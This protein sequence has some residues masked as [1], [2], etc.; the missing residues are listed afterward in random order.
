MDLY[1]FGKRKRDCNCGDRLSSSCQ[2]DREK[3]TSKKKDFAVERVEGKIRKNPGG[4]RLWKF[5]NNHADFPKKICVMDF[6]G[7]RG[8]EISS[9]VEV[10]KKHRVDNLSSP[11]F[12]FFDTNHTS[13]NTFICK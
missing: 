4:M 3:K 2:S 6:R 5:F 10:S 9:D 7:T 11:I 1:K 13:G 12:S 8:E